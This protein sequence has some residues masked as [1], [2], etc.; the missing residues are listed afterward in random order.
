MTVRAVISTTVSSTSTAISRPYLTA[1]DQAVLGWYSANY[2]NPEAP[3]LTGRAA[4]SSTRVTRRWAG[5]TPIRAPIRTPRPAR[6]CGVRERRPASSDL[7][8][9]GR[10][11]QVQRRRQEHAHP[12][13]RR[14]PDGHEGGR[15]GWK[16][17]GNIFPAS[18]NNL[19]FN[20]T[21]NSVDECL[22]TGEQNNFWKAGRRR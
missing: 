18:L 1:A 5:S 4:P 2:E 10:H 21:S 12:R 8:G 7:Y 6:G 17:V 9:S 14:Q 16:P 13:P 15:T 11:R 20:A 19:P 3:D 22:S